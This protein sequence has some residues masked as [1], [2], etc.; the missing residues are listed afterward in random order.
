MAGVLARAA[1]GEGG[2]EQHA[3]T[4]GGGGVDPLRGYWPAHG[5]DLGRGG[6]GLW[7][8]RKLCDHVDLSSDPRGTTVRLATALR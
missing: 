7:L 1:D 5:Q 2:G 3:V 6:M 4:D 8:A